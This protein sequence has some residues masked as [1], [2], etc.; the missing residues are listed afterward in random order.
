MQ[1]FPKVQDF[2]VQHDYLISTTDTQ[3][4]IRKRGQRGE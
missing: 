4:R 3:Y 2:D 1:V